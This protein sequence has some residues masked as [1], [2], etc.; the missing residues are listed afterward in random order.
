[1]QSAQMPQQAV[2]GLGSWS[3]CRPA[4]GSLPVDE[5]S[6]PGAHHQIE[7]G[8][9]KRSASLSASPQMLCMESTARAWASHQPL[10]VP[11]LPHLLDQEKGGK[12]AAWC[13]ARIG[14]SCYTDVRGRR[15]AE[16][17]ISGAARYLE[18]PEARGYQRC[19]QSC[20]PYLVPK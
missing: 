9:S 8:W 15:P 6:D 5:K 10:L 7:Q 20:R 19:L 18:I 16:Q 17:S 2:L 1:M 12:E 13:V 3:P 4:S 11:L 14:G